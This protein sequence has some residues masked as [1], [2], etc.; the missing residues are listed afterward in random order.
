M[1]FRLILNDNSSLVITKPQARGGVAEH[2]NSERPSKRVFFA[3]LPLSK[4]C[5]IRMK[6]LGEA[7]GRGW[8]S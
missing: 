6:K 1:A 4:L 3:P 5:N 2:P 7:K 8:R